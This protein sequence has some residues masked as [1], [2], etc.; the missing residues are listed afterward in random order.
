MSVEAR[1]ARTDVWSD[2]EAAQSTTYSGG[3]RD[4]GVRSECLEARWWKDLRQSRTQD[5]HSQS[6]QHYR[7]YEY[8]CHRS[9]GMQIH[10][11]KRFTP[12]VL[13]PRGK[14]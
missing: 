1:R 7:A 6:S 14:Y 8:T 4:V 13:P 2:V 12:G 10:P 9:N 5:A 3:C 11:T